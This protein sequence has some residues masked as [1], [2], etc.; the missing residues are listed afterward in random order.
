MDRLTNRLWV[1]VASNVLVIHAVLLPVLYFG[2]T[3]I[4]ERS[5]ADNFVGQVRTYGRLL[6]DELELGDALARP[7]RT[8]ALLDSII[9]SGQGVY[10]ELVDGQSSTRSTLIDPGFGGFPGDDFEFDAHADHTYFLSVPVARADRAT[11]LRLGFDE[12]PTLDQIQAARNR[13][14]MALLAFTVVSVGLGIWLAARIARPMIDLQNSARSIATGKVDA[15]LEATSSI[16]EVKELAHDL[17]SMRSELVGTSA[18]LA[19]EMTERAAAQAQQRALE[20]RLWRRERIA[21]VGTLA[22]GIAH[23]FN[24][25]MTP[26]LLYAQTALDEVGPAGPV[27]EDLRRVIAAAHRARALVNRVLTFS[28]QIESG[29]SAQVSLEPVVEEVLALLRATIQPNIE[30]IGALGPNVP[31]VVGDASLVH[32]LVM[33]LCTNACQAMRSTGGRLTVS[34]THA[35]RVADD[36][37]PRGD[38][39]VLE[40]ADTGHGMDA[41]TMERIFEPFFTTREVG[42]GTGLGLSVAHGISS[43]I[44][45]T[46]VVDSAP[47]AGAAFKVY[48]PLGENLSSTVQGNEESAKPALANPAGAG[49]A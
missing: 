32:Q 12:T 26:I 49:R 11:V 45:A 41:R 13:I 37:V 20:Q 39:V 2:L 14:I 43:S 31:P 5:H 44:G 35:A 42:E 25:I 22:G 36:R 34:V 18:R 38:Y 16:Y 24:N 23:E 47:E 15:H 48:F 27:A 4:V 7:E 21:T 9:L 1:R 10:A 6:A 46:I 8:I 3:F 29:D 40:V 28:R 30:I 19:R 17:E 33:N